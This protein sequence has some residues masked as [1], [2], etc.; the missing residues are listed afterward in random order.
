MSDLILG[1]AN[2]F[3]EVS[4][5]DLQGLA[6]AKAQE[7]IR[8]LSPQKLP[9]ATETEVLAQAQ[10]AFWAVI[11]ANHPECK[12]GD[13]SPDAAV[14]F[15]N[16]CGKAVEAWL[17]GNRGGSQ[18]LNP[19]AASLKN[20]AEQNMDLLLGKIAAL[21]DS[22][23][24]DGGSDALTVV[25]SVGLHELVQEAVRLQ[26]GLKSSNSLQVQYW[27]SLRYN[28]A[29]GTETSLTFL[30]EVDDRRRT[31]QMFIDVAA[32]GG[33]IDDMMGLTVEVNRLPGTKDDTQCLHLHFNHS[34]LAATFFKHGDAFIVR[35]ETDVTIRD[36]VL[37]NGERGYI[38]K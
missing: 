10:Q 38:I 7:I 9:D 37:P 29:S 1:V 35:P 21:N 3:N 33:N 8:L 34:N 16:A 17:D 5:G 26:G 19:Q 23:C 20:I 28:P 2:M 27:D 22:A 13:F 6:D 14:A 25:S 4:Y 18:A 30:M 31:G 36:F 32:E 11:A 15:D 12:S 24:T